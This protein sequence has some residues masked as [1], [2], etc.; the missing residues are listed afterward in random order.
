MKQVNKWLTWGMVAVIIV[1]LLGWLIP[2]YTSIERAIDINTPAAPIYELLITPQK[3]I[4][5]HPMVLEDPASTEITY[6]GHHRGEGATM[7]W[8][9]DNS[10][11]GS[12]RMELTQCVHNKSVRALITQKGK[13]PIHTMFILDEFDGYT[14][15]T[16]HY[17]TDYGMNPF[18]H[19]L[20]LFSEQLIGPTYEDGLRN[21]KTIMESLHVEEAELDVELEGDH[22]VDSLMHLQ[23]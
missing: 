6:E 23:D 2:S 9:S 13:S 1:A 3:N 18:K 5:W 4:E 8:N 19:Y 14:E 20:A 15:V 17:D 12:G 7:V 10:S 11:V 21:L 22:L 16:W